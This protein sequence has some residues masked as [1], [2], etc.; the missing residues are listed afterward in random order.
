[1]DIQEDEGEA[2]VVEKRAVVTPDWGWTR[3]ARS[4]MKR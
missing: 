4:V 1:M 2:R 3:L